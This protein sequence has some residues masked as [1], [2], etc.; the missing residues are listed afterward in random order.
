MKNPLFSFSLF[1]ICLSACNTP[2]NQL[3]EQSQGQTQFS[4]LSAPSGTGFIPIDSANKMLSSYLKSLDTVTAVDANLHAVIFNADSLR[5]MLNDETNGKIAHVKVMF[6]HRLDYINSGGQ[7]V[8]CGYDNDALTLIIAGYD[9]VGN[10]VYHPAGK[11][12]NIGSPCP[13]LCPENGTAA[14]NLLTQ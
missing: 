2:E 13:P 1:C 14:S 11:V 12:L 3:T 5:S 10:Y 9:T 4:L 8:N 6:A 7:N